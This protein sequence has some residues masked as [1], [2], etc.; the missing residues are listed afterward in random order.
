MTAATLGLL[1][2][3]SPRTRPHRPV[4][5]GVALLA[6]ALAA[7][8]VASRASPAA[9][10]RHHHHHHRS[11][12]PQLGHHQR[13]PLVPPSPAA[14]PSRGAAAS[15]YL[16][17]AESAYKRSRAWWDPGRGWYRQ[18][19]PG[20]GQGNATAWGIVHLFEATSAIAIADPRPANVAAAR[21][22]GIGAERYWDPNLRPVP[23]YAP[24]PG[25][26]GT[27]AWYDDVAWWGV[28][29]VDAYRATG[30]RRF[31][32]DAARSLAFVDSGWDPRGG[33]IYWDTNRTFVTS[34]S[35]AGATLIA[36]A[37]YQQ[38]HDRRDLALAGKYVAWANAH[39]RGSDGLYGGRTTPANPMPYVE[40]PMAEAFLRLCKATGRQS[41]CRD[42]EHVMQAAAARFPTLVMGPQYDSLYVRAVLEVYRL[43]HDPRWYRVA[44]DAAK[45]ARANAGDARGLQM[46]TWDGQSITSIGTPAGKLQTHAATTSVFAWMAAARPPAGG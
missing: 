45:R 19:L 25:G 38:T 29:F 2:P 40:G 41:W 36:A 9:R 17:A 13:P 10:A 26:R 5:V 44:A 6:L 42:G 20:Y 33:G 35:L 34:E 22:F 8:A 31:L 16:A 18:F 4:V 30:D 46:R 43:D 27:H 24:S 1:P 14:N 12:T 37:L 21:S 28:A 32:D 3:V 15:P 11:L 39:L 23:G 7:I